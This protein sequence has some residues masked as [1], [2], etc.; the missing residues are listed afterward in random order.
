MKTILF[1]ISVL[2]GTS[3]AQSDP[4]LGV[5]EL[6]NHT[7]CESTKKTL[8]SESQR[9]QKNISPYTLV[10]LK[11]NQVTETGK[12]ISPQKSYSSK[13]ILFRY[14][15]ERIFFLDKRSKTLLEDYTIEKLDETTL[16]ISN[17]KF[18][19]ETRIF[20]RIS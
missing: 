9:Q 4:L 1:I 17:S 12:I 7:H 14:D 8:L 3:M 10:F 11:N 16:V 13:A 6:Q 20:K 18:P 15:G 2:L 19:C 5:W